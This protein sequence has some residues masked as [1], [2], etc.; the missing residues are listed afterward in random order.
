MEDEIII[1]ADR[2]RSIGEIADLPPSFAEDQITRGASV[3]EAR[4]AARAAM[5]ER[6][7]RPIRVVSENPA[8][9]VEHRAE[10]LHVRV[11]G[12]TPSEQ[13]RPFMQDRLI[14]H[15]RAACEAAGISTRGL[16]TDEVFTRAHTTSDF[17]ALLQGV[18]ARS[19]MPAYQAA[20]SPLKALARQ[21][22]ANDFRPMSRLKL[23]D[24]GPLQKLSESGEIKHTTRAEAVESY[25]L[26]SYASIFALSRK[27]L[28]ND[29]LGAF[30]DWAAVAGRAAAQ[31]EADVLWNLLKSNPKMGEDGKA[32]FHADHG[33]LPTA[34]ALDVDAV[35]AARLAL[36]TQKGLDGKTALGLTPKFLLVGPQLET[37]ADQIIAAIYAASTADVNPYTAKLVPLVEPRITDKSWYVFADTAAATILEYAYL[38]SAP[39]PQLASREGWDVLGQEFRVVLDFGAGAV[40]WR[41]AVKNAG[42]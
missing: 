41:G 33:N 1:D 11:A 32:L 19:L 29:D 40:D 22:N 34:S 36:R 20:Q 2:I 31:T 25:A 37:A 14:D 27:A 23:S 35:S 7:T 21:V 42:Q 12:G 8:G 39:G 9:T 15:A 28:V 13:A 10:A 17:P 26:D 16:S 38:S 6:A 24:T 4:V 18:G 3:E 30:R 5:V